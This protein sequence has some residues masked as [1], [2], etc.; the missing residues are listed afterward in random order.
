MK[1]TTVNNPF[2]NA[3][4]KGKP[5]ILDGAMGS[6][7]QQNGFTAHPDLWM[8][9]LNLTN[10]NI[11]F[12]VHKSY[13]NAGAD[14]I[15]TNTFRT[16]PAA[17]EGAGYPY[18]SKYVREAVNIAKDAS[19]NTSVIIA[20]SNPPAED[21]YQKQRKISN[22][23]LEINHTNHIDLLID[24]GVDFILNE[25]QS[26]FD[27]IKIICEHCTRYNIPYILSFYFDE[28][29]TILSGEH[30]NYI[31]KYSADHNP[32]AIGFNCIAPILFKSM[33][34]NINPTGN[35]GF[36]LNCGSGNPQDENIKCGISPIEYSGMVGETFKYEPSFVGACCG[37]NPNHIKEIKKLYE[38]D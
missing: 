13:I 16:N 35:W 30:L 6:M 26:H 4:E 33:L 28:N 12:N 19:K 34:R 10:A 24:N 38:K 27:E 9:K 25:T 23:L 17:F 18:D 7:L 29:L 1:L 8:S 32:L 3:K 22:K 31:L 21:C 5:L 36:Y 2:S 37:S 15:T 14:I 11:I 20:G